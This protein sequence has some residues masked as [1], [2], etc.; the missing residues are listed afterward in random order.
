M[1]AAQTLKQLAAKWPKDPVRPGLQFG[2]FLAYVAESTPSEKIPPKTL[3]AVKALEENQAMKKYPIG[4]R[5]IK[6]ASYPEHYNRAL[7][8]YENALKGKGRSFFQM[9][10]GIYK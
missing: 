8:G 1:S 10:F 5:T 4:S 9:F 7:L 2:E 3:A 6:P